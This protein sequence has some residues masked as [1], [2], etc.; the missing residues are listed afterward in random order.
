MWGTKYT[1]HTQH[2]SSLH[3]IH[4]F[5]NKKSTTST[6][7]YMYMPK[8]PTYHLYSPCGYALMLEWAF[9]VW[10]DDM[11]FTV[12]WILS[13]QQQHIN[14]LWILHIYLDKPHPPRYY[15]Y[16]YYILIL[17]YTHYATHHTPHTVGS[18]DN[19]IQPD[20]KRPYNHNILLGV[21]SCRM[22]I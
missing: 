12:I 1:Q 21:F 2:T 19:V 16:Y 11:I 15:Y 14:Q 13:Q 3:P 20:L 6:S 22:S 5:S 9:C 4:P 18:Y 17:D 10:I 7:T 8:C